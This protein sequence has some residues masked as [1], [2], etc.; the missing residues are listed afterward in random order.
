[1]ATI[2]ETNEAK[3]DTPAGVPKVDGTWTSPNESTLTLT[4]LQPMSGSGWTIEGTTD[5]GAGGTGF[6]FGN[7]IALSLFSTR[8]PFGSVETVL[9][10]FALAAPFTMTALVSTQIPGI[11]PAAP[12]TNTITYTRS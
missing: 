10:S 7:A 12:A 6:T 2:L 8:G 4:S 1:V 11:P 5:T 9:G 3:V